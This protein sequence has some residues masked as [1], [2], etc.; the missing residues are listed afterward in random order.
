MS[1]FVNIATLFVIGS[2]LGW[3]LE[4]FFRRFVSQKKWMNPGFMRGPYLPIYGFGVAILYGI[5]AIPMGGLPNYAII[6]IK[7]L[8]IGGSM[9]LLELIGGLFFLNVFNMR[10]WDYSDRWGNFKGVIC[11]LF[12]L[13]WM[14]IGTGFYFILFTQFT[15]LLEA[16]SANIIYCF[17][18]GIVLGMILVDAA[19]SLKVGLSMRKVFNGMKVRYDVFREDLRRDVINKTKNNKHLTAF[20]VLLNSKREELNSFIKKFHDKTIDKK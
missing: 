2:C 1:A 6:L 16:L 7:V 20:G 9:T 19:Y 18:V 12:S 5:W 13:I 10:L 15:K 4:V 14:A 11:P 17:F 8:I 3:V